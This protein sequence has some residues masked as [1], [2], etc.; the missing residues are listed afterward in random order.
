MTIAESKFDETIDKTK[1]KDLK[2]IEHF[3]GVEG[4]GI[5]TGSR[6]IF[7]RFAGCSVKCKHC[8]TPESWKNGVMRFS[9][10]NPLD[11][12]KEI[13]EKYLNTSGHR[14]SRVSITGGNPVEQ[15]TD[16]MLVFMAALR[17]Q[18]LY[19]N[20]EHPGIFF[21][22]AAE[23]RIL[24]QVD[25]LSFDIKSPSAFTHTVEEHTVY[26]NQHIGKLCGILQSGK[27]GQVKMVIANTADLEFARQ[28]VSTL[29]HLHGFNKIP[30][31]LMPCNPK[32]AYNDLAPTSVKLITDAL[33]TDQFPPNT[34][35]GIQMH[36]AFGID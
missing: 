36:K 24:D 19:I 18:G 29:F 23:R 12:A 4:E 9:S 13:A 5:S 20:M 8:D 33:V 21:D 15:D 28:T 32:K 16:S 30:F 27:L 22:Y 7:V 17:A 3:M 11:L 14:C 34:R 35:M 25:F 10:H 26:T 31:I 1:F 2:V 6:T